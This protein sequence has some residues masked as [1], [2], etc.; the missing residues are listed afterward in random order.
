M[1]GKGSGKLKVSLP[2]DKEILLERE[3]DAPRHLVFEAM[4]RPEHVRRWYNAFEGFTMPVCDIDLRVG[5]R[6]RYVLRSPEGQ[7][8]EF[9]GDYREI[10][11]PERVVNT[12]I[13][14][15]FPAEV[16]VC[17][18]TLAERGDRTYYSCLVVHT[19]KEGRDGHI[20]SGM[21]RGADMCMDRLDEVARALGG[22]LS[23]P[24]S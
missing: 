2:S 11:P 17:T 14:A 20:A 22:E 16:T 23:L 24:A 5:G 12:E 21:E 19:T 13:F 8:I 1:I 18:M 3:F 7:E 4:T 15:P 9:Y 10:A 6:W